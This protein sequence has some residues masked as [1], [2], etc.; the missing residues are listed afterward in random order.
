MFTFIQSVTERVEVASVPE[1]NKPFKNTKMI[2]LPG[3][4]SNKNT[5]TPACM[6]CISVSSIA[7]QSHG[8]ATFYIL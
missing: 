6:L 4:I 1:R 8:C 7:V 2:K 5:E 3:N